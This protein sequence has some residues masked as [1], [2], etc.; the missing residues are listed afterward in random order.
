MSALH[1]PTMVSV[2]RQEKPKKSPA[3]SGSDNH[4]SDALSHVS[5]SYIRGEVESDLGRRRILRGAM[6][7]SSEDMIVM[8]II[9]PGTAR[10]M[11]QWNAASGEILSHI[12][13]LFCRR[14]G[15]GIVGSRRPHLG[16]GARGTPLAEH[17]YLWIEWRES[18]PEVPLPAP[19]SH[20]LVNRR[21][22]K[23][24]FV[25]DDYVVTPTR[26]A[27]DLHRFTH[28]SVVVLPAL[29]IVARNVVHG[30]RPAPPPSQKGLC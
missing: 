13:L 7:R 27:R 25:T 30:L 14:G 26:S 9:T 21:L 18:R 15:N 28:L 6:S 4:D 12:R 23:I 20:F 3:S 8:S 16:M 29:R 5:G 17:G 10:K 22:L 1:V 19:P 2:D 24:L 11:P